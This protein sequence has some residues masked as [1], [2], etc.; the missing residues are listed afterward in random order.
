MSKQNYYVPNT[1]LTT[2]NKKLLKGSMWGWTTYG[3]SLAPFNQ[4]SQGKNL[5]PMAS[6]GC[7]SACLFTSGHGSMSTVKKGR[8]NKADFFLSDRTKFLNM[9]YI[10]I[11]QLEL[12][13]K[14]EETKFA[15]RLNVTSDLSWEKFIIPQTGK[16][17]FDSFKNVIFYDYTKNFLRFRNPLPKNYHLTFSRSENNEKI[18]F[19]LIKRGVNI[20][21][22]FDEIPETY[23]GYKVIDG[24][25]SDLRFQDK[26]GVIVG[27]KYKK[28]TGKNANNKIAFESGF[29]L[30]LKDINTL[31]IK[32]AA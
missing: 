4:N 18:A 3:L 26:K 32:R 13:H 24:D 10:E 7:S 23:N 29:A 25:I 2:R 31:P 20:A 30:R 1:L 19:E 9:L 15:V 17:I 14:L 5:C 12:K 11:A 6:T 27:L 21:I 8:I 16:N 22:V 28:L